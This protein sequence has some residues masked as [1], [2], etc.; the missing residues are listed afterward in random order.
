MDA[1]RAAVAMEATEARAASVGAARRR[2]QT[3][4]R[5]AKSVFS[6]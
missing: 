4:G 1:T 6:F 2:R 5:L 3:R